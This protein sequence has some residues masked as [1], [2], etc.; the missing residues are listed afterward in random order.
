MI[1]G[2]GSHLFENTRAEEV[3]DD[4]LAVKCSTHTVT[5]A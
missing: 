4:P 2:D 3:V 1:P 5:C